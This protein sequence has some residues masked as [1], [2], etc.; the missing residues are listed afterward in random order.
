MSKVASNAWKTLARDK[1][2]ASGLTDDDALRLGIKALPAAATKELDPS[3]HPRPSLRINYFAPSGRSTGF[4]RIRYLGEANGF[5]ALT[6]KSPKYVQPPKSGVEVYWPRTIAWEKIAT[7]NDA[8][9]IT[10]GELK[11]ACASKHGFPTIGLGG[12]W[13]WRSAKREQAVVPSLLPDGFNWKDR[14]VYIAFDS[15]QLSNPDVARAQLALCEALVALGARPAIVALPPLEVGAKT[16][17]DDFIVARG[18]QAL[19]QLLID[20]PSFESSRELVKLNNELIYVKDPGLIVVLADSRRMSATAFTQHAY[21]NRHYVETSVRSDGTLKLTKKPLAPAWLAW[22]QRAELESLTYAPGQQR[23]TEDRRY[24]LWRGWGCTPARGD[25]SP[26]KKLLDFLFESDPSARTWFERWCAYPIQHP[27]TKLYTA[28]VLWGVV[29]GTGK[30]LVG[31]SLGKIYG[32]N[33]TEIGEEQLH[34]PFND[35]A[36]AKQF[37]MGDDVTSGERRNRAMVIDKLKNM[38]TQLTLRVNAKFI[39]AFTVPDVINYYFTSNHPDA[40]FLEDTDR[41]FFVHEV[42]GSALPLEFYRSYD[43]WLRKPA[44]PSALFDYMMRLDLGDFDPHAPAPLTRAKEQMIVDNKSDL[45]SWVYRLKNDPESVLRVGSAAIVGDLFTNEELLAL[46]DPER[47]RGVTANGLGRELK[48][49]GLRYVRDGIVV[50][51]CRGRQRLYVVRNFERWKKA[52]PHEAA[53]HYDARFGET[54]TEKKA[55]F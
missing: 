34:A 16:G 17:L 45:G 7:S 31:Y 33:F 14:Q 3:F 26:W 27:G 10:E 50:M 53:K 35:W 5:D 19:Q 39:P 51:T 18:A 9:I 13:S 55:K 40:F 8:V 43:A 54:T 11:A 12:V 44:G 2:A 20:A 15:D 37:V 24:N 36:E 42:V 47:K 28:A 4:Y 38:I 52:T 46:Y 41:R 1:L 48:R 30:S 22:E 49:A 6:G 29:N 23:V 32:S 21:A 25:V